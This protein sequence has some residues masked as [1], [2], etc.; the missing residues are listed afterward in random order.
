MSRDPIQRLLA[1]ARRCPPRPLPQSLP[2]GLESRVLACWRASM[3]AEALPPWL[4][5]VRRALAASL[6]LAAA[7]LALYACLPKARTANGF[8][9]ADTVIQAQWWP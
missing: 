4:G 2:W 7:S 8:A 1:A 9:L 3:L 5:L 6:V